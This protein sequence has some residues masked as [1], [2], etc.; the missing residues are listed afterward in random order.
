MGIEQ[1][2]C[3]TGGG[4]HDSGGSAEEKRK[5]GMILEAKSDHERLYLE[6]ELKIRHLKIKLEATKV[7]RK[8]TRTHVTARARPHAFDAAVTP[9][10][11]HAVRMGLYRSIATSSGR[12]E[13][14]SRTTERRACERTSQCAHQEPALGRCASSRAAPCTHCVTESI[15]KGGRRHA[16]GCGVCL[17]RIESRLR[18][19]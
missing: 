7:I 16:S 14:K 17:L 18:R 13:D 1:S 11:D 5:T 4:E 6:Q 9:A 2:M 15:A 8:S 12:R 19:I 10:V 3:C